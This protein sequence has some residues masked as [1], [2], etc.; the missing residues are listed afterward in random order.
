MEYGLRALGVYT[1]A[2][3]IDMMLGGCT[4]T[5]LLEGE[6]IGNQLQS[7]PPQVMY[8]GR[9]TQRSS[10]ERTPPVIPRRMNMGKNYRDRGHKK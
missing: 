1:T 2:A 6:Q 10:V 7:P 4:Y 9:H 3:A 8:E 5:S